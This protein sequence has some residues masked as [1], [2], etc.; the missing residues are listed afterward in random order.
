[1]NKFSKSPLDDINIKAE[2]AMRE[3]VRDVIKEHKK[4][5]MP[6][7]VMEN[8]KIVRIRPWRKAARAKVK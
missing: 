6:L 8:G 4:L 7:T 1:M 3:A 2:R 5:D